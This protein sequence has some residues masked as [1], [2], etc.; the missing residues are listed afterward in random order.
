MD[1]GP[2]KGTRSGIGGWGQ[3]DRW[4]GPRGLTEDE[5]DITEIKRGR[6]R[7]RGSLGIKVDFP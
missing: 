2:E 1:R 4:A 7:H 5:Q 6:G 3:R